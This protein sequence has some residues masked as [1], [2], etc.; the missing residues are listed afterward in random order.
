MFGPPVWEVEWRSL[1]KTI[2]FS[3]C[4]FFHCG[5]ILIRLHS[6]VSR[7]RPCV[8]ARALCVGVCGHYYAWLS[9]YTEC[10]KHWEHLPNIL[11]S[12][13]PQLV[14]PWTL[15]GVE[16]VPQEC[17]SM[18]TL[19][20]PTDFFRSSF[21]DVL[22]VVDHSWYTQE[23]V[24]HEKPSSVAVLDTNRCARHPTTIPRSKALTSF[25]PLNGTH[26]HSVSIVSRLTDPSLTCLLPLVYTDWSDINK[27]S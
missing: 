15:Q 24:E 2:H 22:W 27:G 9:V 23:T 12:E 13:Q 11:P 25:H 1:G 21:L 18:L 16:S 20:L 19:K 17:W 10:T 6:A 7:V 4:L 8:C 14:W 5:E 3:T 26:T